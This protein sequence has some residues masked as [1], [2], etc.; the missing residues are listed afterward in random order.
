MRWREGVE[1]LQHFVRQGA[2]GDAFDGLM[3]SES[4]LARDWDTP[5][6]DAAWQNL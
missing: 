2:D 1:R 4:V 3:A 5:Q 6:E